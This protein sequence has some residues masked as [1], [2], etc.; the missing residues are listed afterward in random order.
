M[1][2][3]QDLRNYAAERGMT[4]RDIERLI[5]EVESDGSGNITDQEYEEICFGIDCETEN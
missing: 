1:K 5:D 2:T 4:G 3:L